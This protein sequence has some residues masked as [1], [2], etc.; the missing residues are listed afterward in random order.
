MLRR[1]G[2]P[3]R[4]TV[5][6]GAFNAPKPS[7]SITSTMALGI[8]P[9]GYWGDGR[10]G[11]ADG[12]RSEVCVIRHGAYVANKT[13]CIGVGIGKPIEH[14]LAST[15]RN[16]RRRVGRELQMAENLAD[17]LGLVDDGDHAPPSLTAK[18]THGHSVIR[19]G[20]A[21]KLMP[22]SSAAL[23]LETF[24][25]RTRS[26]K[27]CGRRFIRS[28]RVRPSKANKFGNLAASPSPQS[29]KKRR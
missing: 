9:E 4:L 27:R 13:T 29:R 7:K 10:A 5:A 1:I 22:S 2:L 20:R 24:P 8:G 14:C 17:H 23:P 12:K 18:G 25:R 15:G 3:F 6:A 16:H 19:I 26:N 28:E 11:K 21:H